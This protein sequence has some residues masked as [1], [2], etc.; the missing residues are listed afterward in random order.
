M[1]FLFLVVWEKET[2]TRRLKFSWKENSRL[3]PS[4]SRDRTTVTTKGLCIMP[5]TNGDAAGGSSQLI[6]E[7]SVLDHMKALDVLHE[8][9]KNGEGLDAKTLLDSR[10]NGGLTY[11][12]F[13]VLPGYIGTSMPHVL[14][15]NPI[16]PS[17]QASLPQMLLWI[18][19]SRKESP[20]R[21]HWSLLPWTP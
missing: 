12:D 15:E 2:S 4:R 3:S 8:E 14:F 13:L 1:T 7:Q 20:L 19:R 11:N 18:L 10:T 6:P 17:L 21:P 16:D 5:L 9:Y